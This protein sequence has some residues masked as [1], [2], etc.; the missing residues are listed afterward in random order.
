MQVKLHSWRSQYCRMGFQE[1]WV[2]TSAVLSLYVA[3]GHLAV[4][5]HFSELYICSYRL[6]SAL[7]S[8]QRSGQLTSVTA[9]NR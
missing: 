5:W 3:K 6:S 8:M 4:D 1:L 2:P 9:A 7:V